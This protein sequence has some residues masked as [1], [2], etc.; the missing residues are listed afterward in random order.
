MRQNTCPVLVNLFTLFFL[1]AD[2]ALQSEQKKKI[3]DS[4]KLLY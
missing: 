3:K 2:L 4:L 1:H